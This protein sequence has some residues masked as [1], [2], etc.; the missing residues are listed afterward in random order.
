[1]SA[2][3]AQSRPKRAAAAA[4]AEKIQQSL[5]SEDAQ[6]EERQPPEKKA[7]KTPPGL[8]PGKTEPSISDPARHIMAGQQ[9]HPSAMRNRIPILKALLKMLPESDEL[10]GG[11]VL[12]IATGTGALMEVV[13]PA[14]PRLTYQ[15]SEY[16]PEVAAGPEEQWSKHGK[17]GLR[18]G[19]DELANIDDHGCKLFT[20]C[21][22]AVALDLSKPWPEAVAAKRGELTLVLCSN[23][24]HI[25]PWECSCGLFRGAGETLAPGG[26]LVVY[27]PFKVDQAFIG[28]DGGAGNAK[29]DAKL[30]STNAEWG[31]R[32]VG[33]LA[34]LAE[35]SGLTLRTKVAMPANNLALHFV[36]GGP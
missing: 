7:K 26:H 14:F 15:P 25:T 27:G 28:D 4:T 8:G 32:D 11:L 36:K 2:T 19:L 24:L 23:T 17:I 6:I 18:A 12:E 34:A 3:L 30:R 21:L 29:F 22:P 35:P 31:I 10:S 20:N 33:D 1:M 16:V 5:T 13:A 9:H